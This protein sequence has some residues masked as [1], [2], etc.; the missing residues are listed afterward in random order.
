MIPPAP[1]L[2]EIAYKKL[3]QMVY[4]EKNHLALRQRLAEFEAAADFPQRLQVVAKAVDTEN[5]A[6]H[7]EVLTWLGEIKFDLVPK[8]VTQHPKPAENQGTYVTNVTTARTYT[9]EKVNYLFD[10]PIELHLLAVLW[11]MAEGQDFDRSL[12]RHCMGSRLHELVGDYEDHS[13]FLFKKY[14][15]LYAKWR[16]DGIGI[17]RHLLTHDRQSV[18]MLGLDVQEYYYRIRLDWCQLREHVKRSAPSSGIPQEFRRRQILGGRLFDCIEAICRKYHHAVKDHL[19]LTHKDLPDG[20]TCLPIGLCASPVIANWYL[21]EFDAAICSRIR[22]AYYAR[23]IDDILLVIT[24]ETPPDGPEPIKDFIGRVLVDSGVLS[25]DNANRRYELNSRP[26]LY[27]QERKCILQY[28]DAEH[29]IA[30]LDKFQRQI[31]ENASDFALLPLE[32]DESPVAQVAYDLLYDGSVNKVR[33][34]KAIA[35]NRWELARHLAKQTQLHL[36]TQGTLDPAMKAELFNF[37]KGR[38]AIDYWDMW[39]RVISFLLVAENELAARAFHKAMKPAIGRMHF[40]GAQ[41]V[42]AQLRATLNQHLDICLD[43]TLAVKHEDSFLGM[44]PNAWRQSNLIRHHLV[45]VPLLNFT[46][47][48]GDLTAHVDC[49]GWEIDEW[50]AKHSPR[51][52][53]FD[54]CLAFVDSGQNPTAAEDSVTRANKLYAQFH[55]AELADV[56]SEVVPTQEEA[57]I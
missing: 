51:F 16:D 8:G 42:S 20:A 17:A 12:S 46:K 31:E 53:H 13:A 3:K 9:V 49:G 15:E 18:C 44:L 47:F 29:S 22:P 43:L 54:E 14:H 33:S 48:D 4:F 28:F 55:G 36:L 27:L 37:F 32:G 5:T 34:V 45:A 6:N 35:E 38:S 11:L 1:E 24:S 57:T 56:Q 10:G 26:G 2:V 39:E 30:G 23:Y 19:A 41:Q 52:V 25:W 50:K 21:K 40:N 7:P